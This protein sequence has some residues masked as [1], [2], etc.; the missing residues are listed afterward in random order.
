MVLNGD[1]VVKWEPAVKK[2]IRR[3]EIISL[4]NSEGDNEAFKGEKLKQEHFKEL[5]RLAMV[6]N[7]PL[8]WTHI[9]ALLT[10]KTIQIEDELYETIGVF[11][12]NENIIFSFNPLESIY[13]LKL[14]IV[15]TTFQY[16]L[17]QHKNAAEK[18]IDIAKLVIIPGLFIR[19]AWELNQKWKRLRHGR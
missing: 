1:D 8:G 14:N 12:H 11:Q 7:G 3:W 15:S 4:S 13:I 16:N 10:G 2:H 19:G 5:D 17:K 9:M 18:A 6:L